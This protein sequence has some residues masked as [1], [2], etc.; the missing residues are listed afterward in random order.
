M[1]VDANLLIYA[2]DS[3]SP[4]HERARTWLSSQL[5]GPVRVAIPW[6]SIT[7]FVRLVTHPRVMASPLPS[8]T[9]WDRVTDWLDRDVVWTP[10]P[11]QRHAEIFG[12]LIVDLHLTGNLV[13]DA[14]LAALAIEHG[15]VMCSA[16]T[17]FARFPTLTWHNPLTA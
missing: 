1:L 4:H 14:H 16:D 8:A 3:T 11:T 17:D 2:V 13:A 12:A 9:A 6:A 10:V 7:A 5:D 15:L